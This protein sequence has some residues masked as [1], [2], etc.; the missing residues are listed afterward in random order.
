MVEDLTDEQVGT[1]LQE[2]ARRLGNNATALQGVSASANLSLHRL[3][4]R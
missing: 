3:E 1:L 2:A 4:N